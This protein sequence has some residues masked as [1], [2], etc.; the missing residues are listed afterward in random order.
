MKFAIQHNIFRSALTKGSLATLTKDAQ[1]S[2]SYRKQPTIRCIKLTA[3]A[4]GLT[5]ESSA[6]GLSARTFV[7]KSD[8]KVEIT[9]SLCVDTSEMIEDLDKLKFAHTLEFEYDPNQVKSDASLPSRILVKA[10]NAKG[11]NAFEWSYDVYSCR[12]FP[13]V[14][15][16]GKDPQFSVNQANLKRGMDAVGF[17]KKEDEDHI[18][19]NVL[20]GIVNN[21]IQLGTTDRQR[22]SIIRIVN[23]IKLNAKDAL[24]LVN[25]DLLSDALKCY[26]A[27][28][29]IDFV[30]E[31]GNTYLTIRDD[32]NITSFRFSLPDYKLTE[33]F[34]RLFEL[35]KTKTKFT[36]T[37]D[38]KNEFL[39]AT[40]IMNLRST[41]ANY[42]FKEGADEIQIDYSSRHKAA[43]VGCRKIEGGMKTP[44]LLSVRLFLDILQK[45]EGNEIQISVAN[46]EERVFV[47][48]ASDPNY[49]Y[50]MI[51]KRN[52]APKV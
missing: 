29:M 18:L 16:C 47:Q 49:F 32:K 17:T 4:E 31:D 6:S 20:I 15:F 44:M 30:F 46:D 41:T 34:G 33:K 3:D 38:D 21:V 37:I 48:D 24:Y 50:L 25:W 42:H 27:D 14:E 8:V 11:R 39:Q 2:E 19:D 1:N 40:M 36:V 9:G 23:G 43:Q 7:S 22:G 12:S 10:I 45:M 13:K 35:M 5:L 28:D 51:R 52:S 26:D